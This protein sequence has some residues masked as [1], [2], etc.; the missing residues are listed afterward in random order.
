LLKG[1]SIP[2]VVGLYIKPFME[3]SYSDLP[4][5]ITYKSGG[6]EKKAR[7]TWRLQKYP[8]NENNNNR[9]FVSEYSLFH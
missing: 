6:F 9:L 2:I 1:Y 5:P 8:S 3:L 7:K 4:T